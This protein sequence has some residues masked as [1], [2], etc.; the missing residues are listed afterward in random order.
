MSNITK[1]LT[2]SAKGNVTGIIRF[3]CTE[4]E[5][6]MAAAIEGRAKLGLQ[7]ER[8][9]RKSDWYND[10]TYEIMLKK[11]DAIQHFACLAE[12]AKRLGWE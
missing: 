8:V 5:D 1:T 7:I 4:I 10:T 9:R 2:C 11:T 12:E 3:E 6:A